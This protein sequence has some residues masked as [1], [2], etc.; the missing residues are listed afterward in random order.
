MSNA[1]DTADVKVAEIETGEVE[2]VNGSNPNEA[3]DQPTRLEGPLEDGL[4]PERETVVETV[5]S[6]GAGPQLEEVPDGV[7]YWRGTFDVRGKWKPHLV[8]W[9][10]KGKAK[11]LGQTCEINLVLS[12]EVYAS[13]KPRAKFVRAT[14][15]GSGV[16]PG[17]M[18]WN[19]WRERGA[20]Q[21]LIDV[22]VG[23][24]PKPGWKLLDSQPKTGNKDAS[25][26]S[27]TTISGK[28]SGKVSEKGGE[29]GGEIGFS[30]TSSASTEISDFEVLNQSDGDNGAW[31]FQMAQ[32][33]DGN[34]RYTYPY[35]IN[36]PGSN[37][38]TA[39]GYICPVPK[40]A[41]SNLYPA[42][43]VVWQVP[44]EENATVPITV[45]VRQR[46][47]YAAANM[48]RWMSHCSTGQVTIPCPVPL[49]SVSIR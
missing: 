45:I 26:T 27:S 42:C 20:Y 44:I 40:L 34:A 38:V 37:L 30:I 11:A 4:D 39:G 36:K 24:G 41:K 21:D 43:Q 48:L 33:G 14:L 8:T 49:G 18:D 10:T 17:T 3:L 13:E 19:G 6:S 29:G 47:P 15:I 7:P 25:Y 23:P 9:Y 28:V 46:V 35:D 22:Q 2:S 12:V 5:A 1:T 32:M 16:R 31:R